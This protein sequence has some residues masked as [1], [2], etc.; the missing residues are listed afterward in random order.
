MRDD[1]ATAGGVEALHTLLLRHG[2]ALGLLPAAA[3]LPFPP[4]PPL[5]PP[6]LP[7]SDSDGMD[8]YFAESWEPPPP[9]EEEVGGMAVLAHGL[10]VLR[11]L[12]V[13]PKHQVPPGRRPGGCHKKLN[14]SAVLRFNSAI[15]GLGGLTRPPSAELVLRF[16][17]ATLGTDRKRLG[18]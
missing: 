9:P 1:V 6:P 10:R 12:S 16:Y 11:N 3:A 2:H 7:P 15:A 13:R 8:P 18:R 4:P 5:P 17:E 14:N